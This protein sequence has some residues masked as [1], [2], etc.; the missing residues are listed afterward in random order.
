[1]VSSSLKPVFSE[2]PSLK[3]QRNQ[4]LMKYFK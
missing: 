4:E 1:M 2:D 3:K